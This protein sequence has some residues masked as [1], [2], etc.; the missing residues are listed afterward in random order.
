MK[1]YIRYSVSTIPFNADILSGVLWELPLTGLTEE[2]GYLNLFTEEDS[3]LKREKIVEILSSLKR[4]NL[5][6]SFDL[7]EETFADKNWNEEWEKNIQIIEVTDKIVIKPSF[8]SYEPKPDQLILEIE[9]KM[10]FGTGEHASTRLVLKLMSRY[11]Y[12]KRAVLDVGS[13]TGILAICAAKMGAKRVVAIDNNEWCFVNGKENV[14]RN[15]VEEFVEVRMGELNDVDER[16]FDL[17]LANINKNVLMSVS[18]QLTDHLTEGGLLILS[19]ILIVDKQDIL[20]KYN[21]VG[22]KLKDS[23]EEEEW[24]GLVFEK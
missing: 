19:G 7:S 5:I 16:E 18:N 17:I 2:E 20:D 13:G 11:G 3:G 6:E 22:L 14:A 12:N 21:S 10:S 4:E 24:T 15:N 8:K 9:P 1:N 23:M